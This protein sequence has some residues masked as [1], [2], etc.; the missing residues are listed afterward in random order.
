MPF[1]I[2]DYGSGKLRRLDGGDPSSA[3]WEIRV[4]GTLVTS[5]INIDITVRNKTSGNQES[6]DFLAP[7][8]W[9]T[10]G[11]EPAPTHTWLADHSYKRNPVISGYAHTSIR[12]HEFAQNYYLISGTNRSLNIPTIAID[13]GARIIG[14]STNYPYPCSLKFM[15]VSGTTYGFE[16][17]TYRRYFSSV[18]AGFTAPRDFYTSGESRSWSIWLREASGTI[19]T[20]VATEIHRPFINWISGAYPVNR[21]PRVSGRIYGYFL[22]IPQGSNTGNPRNYAVA[23][24]VSP[25]LDSITWSDILENHIPPPADLKARGFNG[26]MLWSVAGFELNEVFAPSD[27]KNLPRGLKNSIGELRDWGRTHDMKV[28]IYQ[29]GGYWGYQTGDWES[30]ILYGEDLSYTGGTDTGNYLQYNLATAT[31]F[32][33]LPAAITEWNINNRDG[34][35]VWSDGMGLDAAIDIAR[36]SGVISLMTELRTMYPDKPIIGENLKTIYDQTLRQSAHYPYIWWDKMRCPL[37]EVIMPGYQNFAIWNR[38]EDPFSPYSTDTG[39][40]YVSGLFE[41]EAVG[42]IPI[43]LCDPTTFYLIPTTG[44]VPNLNNLYSNNRFVNSRSMK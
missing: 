18:E 15:M 33:L 40:A 39:R 28:Y 1:N 38:F 36:N 20:G 19:S 21:P 35:Y 13:N 5:G 41:S 27:F 37:Q 24:G 14:L 16:L 22:S 32:R 29:G 10:S 4:T 6:L 12:A 3:I 8:G 17:D 42:L 31:R 44:V 9:G 11:V 34:W 25:W 23:S 2:N 7:I 43:T 26:V 30:P